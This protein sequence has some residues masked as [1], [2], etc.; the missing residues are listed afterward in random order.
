VSQYLTLCSGTSF[1]HEPHRGRSKPSF[2]RS[3]RLEHDFRAEGQRTEGPEA[4]S[5]AFEHVLVPILGS[6]DADLLVLNETCNAT[7]HDGQG[8][9]NLET[10][11]RAARLA[12]RG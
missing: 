1:R 3:D 5:H 8:E 4:E 2:Q 11:I 12:R 7:R 6:D 10:T 9:D